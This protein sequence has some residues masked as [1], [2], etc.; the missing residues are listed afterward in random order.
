LAF[1]KSSR[2]KL[3]L[4]ILLSVVLVASIGL[5]LSFP[6]NTAEQHTNKLL[7]NE[8][9]KIEYIGN[10][11]LQFEQLKRT[12]L[13]LLVSESEKK[14]S[15]RLDNYKKVQVTAT[16]YTAGIE[17]TG[18]AIDHPDYGVT[19]SGVQVR[20]DLYSTVAADLQVFPLGTVLYIPGYGYG[21]VSDKGSAIV[22]NRIDLYFDTVDEVYEQWGK[23]SVTVYV[24]EYGKG[25]VTETLLNEYNKLGKDNLLM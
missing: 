21:V 25:R 3:A 10:L 8:S 20:R 23:K 4:S 5:V 11:S 12:N 19:Y 18:K 24:I 2:A 17:S 9:N 15:S 1:V 13:G 6:K 16:G 14:E 7:I 22:G